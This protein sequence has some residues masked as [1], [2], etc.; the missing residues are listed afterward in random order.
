MKK[1]LFSILFA[2]ILFI[3]AISQQGKDIAVIGYFAGPST[4][5]DNFPIQKLSHL[6]FSFVH[7]KAGKL[8][9]DRA[10]DSSRYCVHSK[11]GFVQTK[12]SL[13]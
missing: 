6:N 2:N 13:S 12:I 4:A 7:L 1:F 3:S 11:N 5:L 10:A 8:S 9:V